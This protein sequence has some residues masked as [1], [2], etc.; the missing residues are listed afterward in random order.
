[1]NAGTATPTVAI[2]DATAVR[3]DR[4]RLDFTAGSWTL[5][6]L[7]DN[8]SVTGA[9]PLQL[10]GLSI[11]V[12]AGAPVGGDSFLIQPGQAGAAGF[13]SSTSNPRALAAAAPL[14]VEPSLDNGG[15]V[16]AG[17]LTVTDAVD[18]PLSG[19]VTL[20]F[21]PDALGPG[22][23]GFD[24][25]GG[26][27][28][29]IAYDPNTDSGGI[30]ASLG[31]TGVSFTLSGVPA[32]G[33]T[34]TLSNTPAASGD[35]RNALSLAGLRSQTLLEG[36]TRSYQDVY[37][38]MLSGV[39]VK[40]ARADASLEV[41]SALLEQAEANRSSISGVNLDELERQ[42]EDESTHLLRFQQQ[43]QAAAQIIATADLVFS[44][45]LDAARR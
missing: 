32:S 36:G 11:D 28:T 6:R 2:S 17:G 15:N 42:I 41:E 45:L 18:L 21:N 5:T 13:A 30:S 34:L 19:P 23:P 37:G 35:N 29:T 20:T 4:Y 12:S 24:V 9:G 14:A 39:A 7:S 3:A 33:D 44:T 16:A 25:T 31:L 1:M 40:T 43:Y 27:T 22:V 38:G 10:D 8:Q 26:I